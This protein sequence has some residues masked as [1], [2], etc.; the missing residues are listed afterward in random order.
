LH[1]GIVIF[2]GRAVHVNIVA[3]IAAFD[4]G[5]AAERCACVIRLLLR[6]GVVN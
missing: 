5:C 6:F 1:V 3:A 4:I 2:I